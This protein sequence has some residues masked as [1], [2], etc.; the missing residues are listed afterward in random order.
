MLTARSTATSPLD[1]IRLTLE[2]QLGG[3]EIPESLRAYFDTVMTSARMLSADPTHPPAL[4]PP[5]AIHLAFE[6]SMSESMCRQLDNFAGL[7]SLDP[8]RAKEL[9]HQLEHA[10]VYP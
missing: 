4:V 3:R 5:E 7:E 8:S 1:L 9:L 2:L 6:L 10:P